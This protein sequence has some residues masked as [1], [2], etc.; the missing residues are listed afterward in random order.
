[1]PV[2]QRVQGWP[3]L[4]VG[5][6]LWEGGCGGRQVAGLH[7]CS[8]FPSEPGGLQVDSSQV[9]Q[10]R[11]NPVNPEQPVEEE[12]QWVWARATEDGALNA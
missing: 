7:T 4:A 12:G 10:T 8:L 9:R 5:P 3:P 2:N 1:M 11:A 6:W